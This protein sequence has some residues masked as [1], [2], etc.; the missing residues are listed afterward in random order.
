MEVYRDYIY[1]LSSNQRVFAFNF[2]SELYI[3]HASLYLYHHTKTQ[4]L[5]KH[6]N[7]YYVYYN[8]LSISKTRV[9]QNTLCSIRCTAV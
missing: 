1:L 9:R 6:I 5:V 2:Y 7:I 3:L 4:F 8:K